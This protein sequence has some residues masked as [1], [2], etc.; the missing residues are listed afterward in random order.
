[1]CSFIIQNEYFHLHWNLT[2]Y[3]LI[4]PQHIHGV[5]HY[6]A[7]QILHFLKLRKIFKV[8]LSKLHFCFTNIESIH[9]SNNIYVTSR[10]H[11]LQ[12]LH[13][14]VDF[15]CGCFFLNDWLLLCKLWH[16]KLM[17]IG[18][19]AFLNNIQLAGV[20]VSWFPSEILDKT[21]IRYSNWCVGKS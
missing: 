15:D 17:A 21:I 3:P 19:N 11:S 2:H 6:L 8:I 10:S 9:F 14:F 12:P 1:M 20:H 16:A 5:Q 4:F 7:F 18:L 13:A